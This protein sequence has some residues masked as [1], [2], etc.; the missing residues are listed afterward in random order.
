MYPVGSWIKVADTTLSSV[1]FTGYILEHYADVKR[2]KIQLTKN[3]YGKNVKGNLTVTV[4]EDGIYTADLEDGFDTSFLTDL[5]LDWCL[6][7]KNE[8]RFFELVKELENEGGKENV[9][10]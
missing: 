3:K 4:H 6:V 7:Q 5:E 2:Y 10:R 9:E 8:E 1:D